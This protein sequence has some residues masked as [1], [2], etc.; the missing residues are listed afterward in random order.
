MPRRSTLILGLVSLLGLVSSEAVGRGRRQCHCYQ[1]SYPCHQPSL[2]ACFQPARPSYGSNMAY[3]P[4][5][6]IKTPSQSPDHYLAGNGGFLSWGQRV[7]PE[8][9]KGIYLVTDSTLDAG[10]GKA[11]YPPPGS[12]ILPTSSSKLVTPPPLDISPN[13]WMGYHTVGSAQGNT[14]FWIR[15]Y[16]MKNS[17]MYYDRYGGSTGYQTLPTP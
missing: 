10:D 8:T 6:G 3:P 1:P 14:R 5:E 13:N 4:P 12:I 16:F 15:V 7:G 9:L 17:M 11:P 2:Q